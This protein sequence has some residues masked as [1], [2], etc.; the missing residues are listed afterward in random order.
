MPSDNHKSINQPSVTYRRKPTYL[1]TLGDRN[2]AREAAKPTLPKKISILVGVRLELR[3]AG[4]GQD[5]VMDVDRDVLLV[6]ARELERR[7]HEVLL[8]VLVDVNPTVSSQHA[9][10]EM[11]GHRFQRGGTCLGRRT[12]ETA[13]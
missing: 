5:V 8:L 1:D 12:R 11:C 9:E 10:G 13:P 7:G 3:L 6:Q 2:R 4:D